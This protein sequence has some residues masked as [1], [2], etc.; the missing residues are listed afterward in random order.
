MQH[1]YIEKASRLKLIGL[2][3]IL[4][5]PILLSS[6]FYIFRDQ[7]AIKTINRGTLLQPAISL[8]SLGVPNQG[9]ERKWQI[10]YLAPETCDQDCLAQKDLLQRIHTALGKDQSR[11]ILRSILPSSFS[12]KPILASLSSFTENLKTGSVWIVDPKGCIILQYSSEFLNSQALKAKGIL[13]DL[14][15]LLRLSHVR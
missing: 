11:V 13:E 7:F 15:R 6:L 10:F 1:K 5:S 9:N 8:A 3:L 12:D 2:M 4:L 14:R